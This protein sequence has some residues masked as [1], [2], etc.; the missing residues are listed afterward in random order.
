M[1][2]K[3]KSEAK[4]EQIDQLIQWL[5]GQNFNVHPVTGT[6]YTL[7]GLIG[8]T[9]SIDEDLI[10]ALEI[11]D[12]VKRIQEPYKAANKKFHPMDSVI[13]LDNGT[14]I[15]GGNFVIMA[16]PCCVESEEQILAVARSVKAS[17]ASVLRGGAFKPRTSPYSFQGMGKA[18]IDL[19]YG[20]YGSVSTSVVRRGGHHTGR[21]T[22]HAKL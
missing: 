20:S 22:Q 12:E 1:I 10:R 5:E 17:G 7:L 6:Q 2:I 14:K 3:V 13:T 19:R 11:V 21:C 16:G 18:G 15:G 4:K 8:D 9:T